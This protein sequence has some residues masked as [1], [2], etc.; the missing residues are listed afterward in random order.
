MTA[1]ANTR[2]RERLRPI[3]T[4]ALKMSYRRRECLRLSTTRFEKLLLH[5]DEFR[6]TGTRFLRSLLRAAREPTLFGGW[7]DEEPDGDSSRHP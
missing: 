7:D 2:P 5:P 6:K 3:Y 1:V 4:P